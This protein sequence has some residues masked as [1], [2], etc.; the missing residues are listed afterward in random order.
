MRGAALHRLGGDGPDILLIHGFGADRL[1]WLALAPQLFPFATVWAAEY[2]GHGTAGNDVGDGA[3]ATLAAAIEGDIA[4]RLA[5]PLVVGHSL[6]GAVALH[7]AARGVMDMSGLVLLAPAG[8]ADHPDS[9]FIDQLPEVTDGEAALA[10]LQ[11]LVTRK[12]LITRRMA[13]AFVET[14]TDGSRRAALRR[15]AAALKS[16]DA[17]PPF[18]PDV[19]FTVMWGASDSILPPPV[20]PTPGLRMLPDVGHLPQIEAVGEVIE[21]VREH[22]GP[23]AG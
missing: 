3:P 17:T 5:R 22:L 11:R 9:G 6:G 20:V 21:A 14:L 10:L 2:G 19:P 13:D 18:P 15:I 12:V 8:V 16:G 23:D 7:M 1:S 4:G